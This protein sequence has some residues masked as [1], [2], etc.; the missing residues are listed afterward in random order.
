MP[1]FLLI[2]SNYW[3]LASIGP[4]RLSIDPALFKLRSGPSGGFFTDSGSP[5]AVFTISAYRILRQEMVQYVMQ[6]IN[7][8]VVL[9]KK[10]KVLS[11]FAINLHNGDMLRTSPVMTYHLCWILRL[12]LNRFIP[13]SAWLYILAA[14]W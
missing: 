11:I 9:L 5:Y 14:Y 3:V 13:L 7:I 4:K 12:R 2:M 1:V 8:D 6:S 10:G